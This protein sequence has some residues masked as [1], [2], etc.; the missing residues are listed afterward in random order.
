[1]RSLIRPWILT[2]ALALSACGGG[3]GSNTPPNELGEE[4]V[5]PFGETAD[6]GPLTLKFVAVV[7]EKRCP[8]NAACVA[9]VPG[10][11]R[12]QLAVTNGRNSEVIELNTTPPYP[13]FVVFDGYFIELHSLDPLPS[14]PYPAPTAE[15]Y[16]AT[17][18][19]DGQMI[20]TGN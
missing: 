15:T 19:V 16:R 2:S 13:D 17:M 9:L 14:Y 8:I 4:F 1:M 3:D 11:A 20:P 12:I 5:L 7:E 10:N 18:F 6:V